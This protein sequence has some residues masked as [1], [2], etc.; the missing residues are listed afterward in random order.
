[1][2][3]VIYLLENTN[4]FPQ[5]DYKKVYSVISS[6]KIFHHFNKY[7]DHGMPSPPVT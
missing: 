6:H 1:M 3:Y 7:R 4:P 5:A 2:S